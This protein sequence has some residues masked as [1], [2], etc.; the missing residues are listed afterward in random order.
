MLPVRRFAPILQKRI[1]QACSRKI[2]SAELIISIHTATS[3]FARAA[4]GNFQL[5]KTW[6]GRERVTG[7]SVIGSLF[8]HEVSP[9]N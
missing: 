6:L 7:G 5:S 8:D 1:Y 3:S 2:N 9:Q 4:T